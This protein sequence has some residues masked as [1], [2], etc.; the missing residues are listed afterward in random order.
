M[1]QRLTCSNSTMPSSAARPNHATLRCPNGTITAAATNGPIAL[2]V[3]PPT[4]NTDC[5]RP[6]RPPDANRATRD[7][8]G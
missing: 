6:W 5:A 4:W 7:D 8:S 2:P 3:L 1:C